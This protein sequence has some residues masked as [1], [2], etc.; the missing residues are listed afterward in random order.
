MEGEALTLF[1]KTSAW[2]DEG[3]IERNE[4]ALTRLAVT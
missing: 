2:D 4:R 3:V 1:T